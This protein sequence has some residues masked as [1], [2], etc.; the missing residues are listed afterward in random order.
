MGTWKCHR[1]RGS[2]DRDSDCEPSRK[3]PERDW[4]EIN[5]IFYLD[6]MQRQNIKSGGPRRHIWQGELWCWWL[7]CHSASQTAVVACGTVMAPLGLGRPGRHPWPGEYPIWI[8]SYPHRIPLLWVF[9]PP[10]LHRNSWGFTM[11]CTHC[12]YSWNRRTSSDNISRKTFFF[13]R[14]NV[15]RP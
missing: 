5:A 12:A 11:V 15:C 8:A 10:E 7:L 9:P 2:K 6:P 13:C 14:Y 4:T 1:L 3:G